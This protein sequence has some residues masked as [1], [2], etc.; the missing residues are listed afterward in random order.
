M[1]KPCMAGYILLTRHTGLLPI[2]YRLLAGPE[3]L[4][5]SGNL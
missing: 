5:I 4:F 1:E 2:D 3:A